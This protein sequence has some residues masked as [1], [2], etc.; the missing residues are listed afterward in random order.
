MAQ[1]KDLIALGLP[2]EVAKRVGFDVQA[3]AT[4]GSTQGS[5]GGLLTGPG[6]K[7]VLATITSASDA[8]TLPSA[9]DIGDIVI[10][11]N[12]TGSSGFVFPQSGGTLNNGT[13]NQK[14]TLAANIVA[15][16]VKA[17]ATN[18]KCSVSAAVTL[19]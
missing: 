3:K 18:W 4:N 2:A 17:T 7:L 19:S 6:N 11:A 1:A 15:I 10:V 16:F 9:A 5:T 13:A 8:L 14:A 12:L